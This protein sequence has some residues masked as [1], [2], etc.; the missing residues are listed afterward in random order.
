VAG[1]IAL[2]SRVQRPK[3]LG[4]KLPRSIVKPDLGD[5]DLKGLAKTVGKASKQLGATSKTVSKDIQRVG[6]QAERIGKI[7][8]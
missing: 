8:D 5:V 2:K 4:V 1:G 3:V 6:E 7:L